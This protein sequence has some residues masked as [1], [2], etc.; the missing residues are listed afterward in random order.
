MPYAHIQR[1]NEA[2]NVPNLLVVKTFKGLVSLS[3]TLWKSKG[4][5][6]LNPDPVVVILQCCAAAVPT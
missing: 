5:L 2:F 1:A 4:E 6:G 3:R